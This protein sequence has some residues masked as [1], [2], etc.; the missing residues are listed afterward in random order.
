MTDAAKLL[1]RITDTVDYLRVTVGP[2]DDGWIACEPLLAEPGRLGD[3]VHATKAGRGTDR[4]D[5]AMSLFVQGY[6]FRLASLAIGG[7]LTGDAVLDLAPPRTSIALGRH[8]P[9]AV[10][11]D[12]ARLL[13]VDSPLTGLHEMLIDG[14]LARLV[15]AAH[16][17]CRVGEPLLWGNVAAS[18]ASSFGAFAGEL[19]DRGVE[20]RERAER[21]FASARPQLSA[22]GRLVRLGE[23]WAWERRSCCLWYLT[24]S[25][26]KCEDCSLWTDEE[27][28]RRYAGS[29]AGP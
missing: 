9:N 25:G 4:D 10:A 14:H 6:A 8:R 22:A 17:A 11:I 15:A 12:K 24:E 20:I 23:R 2:H 21:F 27:R 26:F 18:C 29:G 28:R 19:P 13:S 3:L 16:E 5:V 7:W 1:A